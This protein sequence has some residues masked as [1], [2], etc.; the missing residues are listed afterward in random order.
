MGNRFL[1]TTL[2]TIQRFFA[3][4]T[5]PTI[6]SATSPLEFVTTFYA[7]DAELIRLWKENKGDPLLLQC[8]LNTEALGVTCRVRRYV[9]KDAK[10]AWRLKESYR[11]TLAMEAVAVSVFRLWCSSSLKYTSRTTAKLPRSPQSSPR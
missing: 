5:T 11:D 4:Y 3:K 8:F 1:S 7:Y 6:W 2:K 9:L 10:E